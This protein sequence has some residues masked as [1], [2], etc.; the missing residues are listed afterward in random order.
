MLLAVNVFECFLVHICLLFDL[1]CNCVASRRL[2]RRSRWAR[3]ARRCRRGNSASL[4]NGLGRG[5]LGPRFCLGRRLILDLCRGR[6]LCRRCLLILLGRG[7]ARHA[8]RE[9][10]GL[11]NGHIGC[12]GQDFGA[13]LR[14]HFWRV[15]GN[16]RRARWGRQIR[17][18]LCGANGLSL[19][20][21]GGRRSIVGLLNILLL[22]GTAILWVLLA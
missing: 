10:F 5:S 16:R 9:N 2:G 20:R 1:N 7:R 21:L 18:P 11:G 8:N 6:L 15:D 12:D 14:G 22:L 17:L 13:T 3:S 4:L 19:D